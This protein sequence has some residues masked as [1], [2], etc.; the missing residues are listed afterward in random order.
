MKKI[1]VLLALCFCFSCFNLKIKAKDETEFERFL[2]FMEQHPKGGTFTMNQ[3]MYMS[4]AQSKDDGIYTNKQTYSILTNGYQITMDGLTISNG[5]DAFDTV[6]SIPSLIIKGSG[7]KRPLVRLA[8]EEGAI[9][10]W[11]AV[12]IEAIDGVAVEI[13]ENDVYLTAH[14]YAPSHI[15]SIGDHA[16]ALQYR[17]HISYGYMCD[18]IL[19]ASGSNAAVLS[20]NS[21]DSMFSLTCNYSML[22]VSGEN[23]K[24]FHN[25]DS[26]NVI[27]EGTIMD[28]QSTT[29]K[30]WEIH[31]DTAS[32]KII[33]QA[34]TAF[35]DLPIQKN[36]LVDLIRDEEVLHDIS[37]TLH[38]DEDAYHK[39]LALGKAF[40]LYASL[41]SIN[42]SLIHLKKEDF[43]IQIEFGDIPKLY[44]TYQ[45]ISEDHYMITFPRPFQAKHL[46]IY[47]SVD[48][49]HWVYLKDGIGA[50]SNGNGMSSAITAIVSVPED[51]H[52]LK[53][54]V[55]GGYYHQQTLQFQIKEIIDEEGS[56]TPPTSTDTDLPDLDDGDQ[57]GNHGQGGGRE[58]GH[59]TP[60]II[61]QEQPSNTAHKDQNQQ[62]NDHNQVQRQPI[63]TDTGKQAD[64]LWILAIPIM[65]FGIFLRKKK[66]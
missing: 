35:E 36:V 54:E 10:S 48:D 1:K 27:S 13:L 26:A 51:M 14:E 18:M 64:A 66:N 9:V 11:I 20:R 61:Q 65:L 55:D 60:P 42:S 5:E 28:D 30:K 17:N 31:S 40:T 3:D 12:S 4:E 53:L 15:S 24:L 41:D 59:Y 19:L 8:C 22:K 57:G 6:S 56:I 47:G 7:A 16:I 33:I 46:N 37:I 34:N 52:Y 32:N 58:E 49:Q 63:I 45:K 43:A 62:E 38:Y 29:L 23:A 25:I 21:Y 39:G 2:V 50:M 44:G